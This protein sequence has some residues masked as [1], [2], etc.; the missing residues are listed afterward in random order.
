MNNSSQLILSIANNS[1]HAH[2]INGESISIPSSQSTAITWDS[3]GYY[4]VQ[5]YSSGQ[6]TISNYQNLASYSH[7]PSLTSA[8]VSAITFSSNSRYVAISHLDGLVGIYETSTY[9][10]TSNY[11]EQYPVHSL[12]FQHTN[13]SRHIAI[14]TSNAVS[15]YS[16]LSNRLV[17]KF[18]LPA[19]RKQ[20]TLSVSRQAN[21]ITSTTSATPKIT[22]AAFSPTHQA[23]LAAADDAGCLTVWNIS[24]QL[25]SRSRTQPR[26][27]EDIITHSRFPSALRAPATALCFSREG[28]L[29]VA[30]F[31]KNLRI[32]DTTLKRFLFTILCPCP[33][34]SIA[35]SSDNKTII[36]GLTDASLAISTINTTTGEGA[37]TGRIK[38]DVP[39]MEQGS[40]I[41]KVIAY[42][43]QIRPPSKRVSAK[44][45]QDSEK[46]LPRGQVIPRQLSRRKQ[47]EN[48]DGQSR[49][50]TLS[51]AEDI[52]GFLDSIDSLVDSRVTHSSGSGDGSVALQDNDIF[53]PI[54]KRRPSRKSLMGGIGL[55]APTKA[56]S[57]HGTI[58]KGDTMGGPLSGY[59]KRS[60]SIHELTPSR[61][62]GRSRTGEI[63]HYSSLA[64]SPNPSQYDESLRPRSAG[65][66]NPSTPVDN[67]SI[68]SFV[69]KLQ[70][71][72]ISTNSKKVSTNSTVQGS[73]VS[74]ESTDLTHIA[75]HSDQNR[76]SRDHSAEHSPSYT[77]RGE[78]ISHNRLGEKERH[79]FLNDNEANA[80]VLQND[81]ADHVR[82]TTDHKHRSIQGQSS[83]FPDLS[84]VKFSPDASGDLSAIVTGNLS[85]SIPSLMSRDMPRS[86]NIVVDGIPSTTRIGDKSNAD[87]SEYIE[88]VSK[89]TQNAFREELDVVRTDLRNDILNIHAELVM[90][91]NHQSN[92]LKALIVERD[93]TI[94]RLRSEVK[95]LRSDNQR[96][97]MKYGLG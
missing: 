73:T 93:Q 12:S 81:D 6:V 60:Q 45:P 30:G 27:T 21:N 95:K 68:D 16:R 50:S 35:F 47:R 52:Q 71:T 37:I 94:H 36:A 85:E 46:R 1:L 51:P 55:E 69:S 22:A 77:E 5:G 92:E 86:A 88:N 67:V 79:S 42:Q 29:C 4:L 28:I 62:S 13:D 34:S 18:T 33:I 87:V 56:R 43:P 31:D 78:R 65:F 75:E 48:E 23:L 32:F 17:S 89:K 58:K 25:L 66:I 2:R 83:G 14:A 90:M 26:L 11:T 49:S 10:L 24:Q 74:Y 84:R 76:S 38:L 9:T 3:S 44:H 40:P 59:G 96:L 63:D 70:E 19:H 7:I 54:S 72:S 91:A 15:V 53:S 61:T 8:S 97:R 41:V 64:A 20:A 80:T 82:E 39:T 57:F